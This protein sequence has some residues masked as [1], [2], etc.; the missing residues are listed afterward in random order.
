MEAATRVN[1]Q[2]IEEKVPTI[3]EAKSLE[4][5]V[6]VAKTLSYDEGKKA[7]EPSTEAKKSDQPAV[8]V[9]V[10]VKSEVV[11]SE[12]P[13]E[14]EKKV[15]VEE[16]VTAFV[17][18]HKDDKV[19][20]ETKSSEQAITVEV[21][22]GESDKEHD[23]SE[24]QEPQEKPQPTEAHEDKQKEIETTADV[25]AVDTSKEEP[26]STT[27][28]DKPTV[29][30]VDKDVSQDI[31]LTVTA[32][33]QHPEVT[34][35]VETTADTEKSSS[36]APEGDKQLE[37]S[38]DEV[39][40]QQPADSS[41]GEADEQPE[42]S[43]S[44]APMDGQPPEPSQSEEADKRQS[45]TSSSTSSSSSA[46]HSKHEDTPDKEEKEE[47]LPADDGDSGED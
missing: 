14:E 29:D 25:P 10:A 28:E 39:D 13:L 35:E 2:I 19:A 8:E 46:S 15:A 21:N 37:S 34:I 43:Q 3:E 26:G 20:E 16:E 7:D 45:S 27:D 36:P 40:K 11:E 33:E 44:T 22:V 30:S 31:T 42:S 4:A 32:D 41:Q 24:D 18:P 9:V 47:S 38:Q 1:L 17:E 12:K 5:I 23:K 6:D